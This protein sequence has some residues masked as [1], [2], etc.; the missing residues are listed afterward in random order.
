[1]PLLLHV[2]RAARPRAVDG[3]GAFLREAVRRIAAGAV[4]T[5]V[6]HSLSGPVPVRT[7]AGRATSGRPRA[8]WHAVTGRD[9]RR[10][11]EAGWRVEP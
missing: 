5:P 3:I 10:R 11:L 9:G 8:H 1:M 7:A 4:D 2:P 6:L